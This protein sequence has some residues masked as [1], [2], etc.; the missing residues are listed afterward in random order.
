[1][2]NLIG[3]QI[4]FAFLLAGTLF[5]CSEGDTTFDKVDENI[6]RGAVL[7]TIS[8][9]SSTFDFFDT[10]SSW[11]VELEEQD[12]KKGGLFEAVRV[13]ASYRNTATGQTEPEAF[14]KTI[15][16]ST[17]SPGPNGLPRGTVS[18][19]F[20]E[21][22]NAT[23]LGVG[24][25]TS[26][27]QF[28][29]RLELVLTDGRVYTNN[30]SGPVSGGTFF[31]SPF[32]YSVQFFCVLADASLF[33]GNYIVVNDAWADYEPGDVVPVETVAGELRFRIL[34]TNNP[35]ISNP[36]TSYMEITIDPS[37]G[38][39]T[40]ASNECFDYGGGFCADVTGTGSV[41]TCTGDIN[42]GVQFG[43]PTVWNFS[44]VKQ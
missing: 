14:V 19:T 2:K 44:L 15:A 43:S 34:S 24:D 3:K 7:R 1:M 20:N 13:Y 18:A 16:A 11:S 17:F 8:V 36:G 29:M 9:T 35:F 6:I 33:D 5:S 28:I 10:T 22:L 21:V 37:D 25:Y 26:A 4:V 32:Q 27:D 23:G 12:T 40:I 30:A 38:S 42:L 31:A 39:V 41:G